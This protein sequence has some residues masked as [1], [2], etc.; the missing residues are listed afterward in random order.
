[1]VWCTRWQ[2][3]VCTRCLIHHLAPVPVKIGWTL[4]R[5]HEAIAVNRHLPATVALITD[6]V[7]VADVHEATRTA[8]LLQER[9]ERRWIPVLPA[10]APHHC[11]L[12]LAVRIDPSVDRCLV[13]AGGVSCAFVGAHVAVKRRCRT[14][15]A[16]PFHRDCVGTEIVA[17]RV[18]KRVEVSPLLR[19]P[20]AWFVR[21]GSERVER[22]LHR[23]HLAGLEQAEV[24]VT[25]PNDG[26][27]ADRAGHV[28]PLHS[29]AGG[30]C[31]LQGLCVHAE[32]VVQ[33][34]QPDTEAR[35]SRAAVGKDIRSTIICALGSR[36]EAAHATCVAGIAV[37]RA[38]PPT[39]STGYDGRVDIRYGSSDGRLVAHCD[40]DNVFG[41]DWA[42]TVA[43]VTVGATA[44]CRGDGVIDQQPTWLGRRYRVQH[45]EPPHGVRF[46]HAHHRPAAVRGLGTIDLD[47]P[48]CGVSA[49]RKVLLP[50]RAGHG[51]RRRERGEVLARVSVSQHRRAALG[52]RDGEAL[53]AERRPQP[54]HGVVADIGASRGG[55][56]RPTYSQPQSS[57]QKHNWKSRTVGMAR[58]RGRP[59]AGGPPGVPAGVSSECLCN[60]PAPTGS[61]SGRAT[62]TNKATSTE[63]SIWPKCLI[64][65]R[66]RGQNY[67]S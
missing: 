17:L 27:V 58:V 36:V 2:Q 15:E 28:H 41:R 44:A 43:G 46:P 34:D 60:S 21:T 57:C 48:P 1:M 26:W 53:P 30:H 56:L 4:C 20:V 12:R 3:G 45:V 8:L 59:G 55:L 37:R 32:G 19:G 33:C 22:E 24:G 11:S 7:T 62:T 54:R 47:L 65:L 16:G 67:S 25:E 14:Q 38:L 5:V 39:V 18:D 13:Y 63:N 29:R 51:E 10:G 23:I 35:T 61:A 50:E 6:H 64:F 40:A 52:D 9:Q 42:R 66:K 49:V 31:R